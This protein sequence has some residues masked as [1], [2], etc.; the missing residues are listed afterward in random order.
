MM[1][2]GFLILKS[3]LKWRQSNI[4]IISRSRRN[5]LSINTLKKLKKSTRNSKSWKLRTR[6]KHLWLR[7]SSINRS[8]KSSSRMMRGLIKSRDNHW[9]HKKPTAMFPLTM[10]QKNQDSKNFPRITGKSPKRVLLRR[11]ELERMKNHV[12]ARLCD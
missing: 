7:K 2:R 8:T 5:T 3:I 11:R 10:F 4:T 1:F 12:N 9:Y 6:N